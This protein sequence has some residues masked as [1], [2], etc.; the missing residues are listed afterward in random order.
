MNS[1]WLSKLKA[2]DPKKYRALM[3]ERER[4]WRAGGGEVRK[5]ERRKARDPLFLEKERAKL[6][7]F[8]DRR[9]AERKLFLEQNPKP[10][11]V[12]FPKRR[13]GRPGCP[14]PTDPKE[15]NREKWRR[16]VAKIN[17]CPKLREQ[18]L[19]NRRKWVQENRTPLLERARDR[20]R[21]AKSNPELREVLTKQKKEHKKKYYA[22]LKVRDPNKYRELRR[23]KHQNRR[24]SVGH[25]ANEIRRK[26][27]SPLP[28]SHFKEVAEVVLIARRVK[29]LINQ[30]IRNAQDHG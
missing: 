14:L 22:T 13:R 17:S 26:L 2:S 19:L 21:L 12:L 4:A 9:K 3:R 1:G 27:S 15:R 29:R 24:R 28:S 10:V 20:K 23:K 16:R 7:R 25:A 18:F 11:K 8:R 30:E 5:R 6:Q